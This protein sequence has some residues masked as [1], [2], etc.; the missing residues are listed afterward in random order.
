VVGY[1]KKST[2]LGFFDYAVIG[3]DQE[4]SR[5]LGDS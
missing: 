2:R 1:H 3:L 4:D 5:D